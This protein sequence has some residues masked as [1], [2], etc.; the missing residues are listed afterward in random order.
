MPE[1][2]IEVHQCS[3]V[4]VASLHN[5]T[6]LHP[7]FLKSQKIVPDDWDPKTEETVC[8]LPFSRVAYTNGIVIMAEP[9]KLR[10]IDTEAPPDVA[11]SVA[12]GVAHRYVGTLPHVKHTGVGI[13]FEVFSEPPDPTAMLVDRF[14]KNGSWVGE[15][16]KVAA[17]GLRLQ[18]ALDIARVGIT[19][20]TAERREDE[21]QSQEGVL[22]KINYHNDI[23][24]ETA[25]DSSAKVQAI[26]SRY[27][28]FCEHLAELSG[29][30]MPGG[31]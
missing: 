26:I 1:M 13:N 16:L 2:T 25:E 7:A 9:T 4:V 17:C 3:V 29:I 12:P 5:P 21:G 8:S 30:L 11:S 22:L 27:G 19:I 15:P 31:E 10:I 20:E 28:E 18:Y 24:A 23:E 6:I 14:I